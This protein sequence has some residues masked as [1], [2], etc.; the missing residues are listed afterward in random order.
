MK[1]IKFYQEVCQPCRA[2]E[3]FVENVLK[4]APD[5]SYDI[6]TKDAKERAIIEKYAVMQTPILLLVDKDGNE[7]NKVV[8]FNPPMIA[9]LFNQRK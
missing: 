9:E 4:S 1:I 5:E 2:V 3:N 8:G 7:V 6:Y